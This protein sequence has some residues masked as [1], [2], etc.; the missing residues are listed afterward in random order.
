MINQGRGLRI[1]AGLGMLLTGLFFLTASLPAEA[2]S[3]RGKQ[4]AQIMAIK[5]GFLS[6]RMNLGAVEGKDF[7]PLYYQ[8]EAEGRQLR[9][10]FRSRFPD[11]LEQLTEEQAEEFVK[12]RLDYQQKRLD[13]KRRYS[14][15]FREKISAWQLA[16]LYEGERDFRRLLIR[17]L[18]QAG[19]KEKR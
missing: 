17:R 6:E 1:R 12:A 18:Q 2:Q 3:G 8:Y 11:N 10:A 9:Q 14:L 13:M 15:L 19:D 16:R 5:S 7:W 4:D